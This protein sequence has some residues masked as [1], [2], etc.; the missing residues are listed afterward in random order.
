L[1]TVRA[2]LPTSVVDLGRL[3]TL[4]L[5]LSIFFAF[6]GAAT[7]AHA[8]VTTVRRRRHD[9][10]VLRT[11]GFTRRQSRLAV[12]WQATLIA[13]AGLAVGI[14]LGIGAGRLVWRSIADRFPVDYVSPFAIVA[15]L[16]AVPVAVAVANALA[17][18]PAWAASRIRPA[19]VLRTE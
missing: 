19:E 10:A 17:A 9:L 16:V 1:Y 7:V 15:V 6:L 14:P 5:V 3:R 12:A 4:P 8:L 18:G 11:L 2:A 13:A